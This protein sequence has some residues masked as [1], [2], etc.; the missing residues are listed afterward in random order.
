MPVFNVGPYLDASI[1]S[2]LSQTL[3]DFELIIINDASTDDG[4]RII[5]MYENIDSRIKFIDLRFNTLGGAG[6]PSNIGINAAKGKYI[7]FVD[8]D[9]WVSKDAFEN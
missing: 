3:V 1:L 6:I 7:G 5:E 2:V 9:D 8:S 4:K